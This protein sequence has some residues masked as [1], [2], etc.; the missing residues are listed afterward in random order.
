MDV[1]M[2]AS[3]LAVK[4]TGNSK[5]NISKRRLK[6]SDSMIEALRIERTNFNQKEFLKRC[7]IPHKT[8]RRWIT[9]ET[10]GKL[11]LKQIKALCRE[12]KIK[13]IEELPD[14]FAEKYPK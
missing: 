13:S 3:Y 12:L 9:G 1:I 8:Y 2:T 5:M 7:G 14:D 4:L 11:S 10:E 6:E